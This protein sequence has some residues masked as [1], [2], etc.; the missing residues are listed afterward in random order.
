MVWIRKKNGRNTILK[1]I[2]RL[3]SSKQTFDRKTKK[4]MNG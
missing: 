4:K 3:D 2:P 1:K